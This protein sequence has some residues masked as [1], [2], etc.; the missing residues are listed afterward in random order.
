VGDAARIGVLGDEQ[1]RTAFKFYSPRSVLISFVYL[2]GFFPERLEH[3]LRT[4]QIDA[5]IVHFERRS[6]PT[7]STV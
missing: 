2:V 4:K 1:R 3:L 5:V 7:S 6:T